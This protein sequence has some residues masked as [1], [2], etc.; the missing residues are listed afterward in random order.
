VIGR[1]A[2]AI[3]FV[4]ALC[5]VAWAVGP[6]T[7]GVVF[8]KVFGNDDGETR[9]VDV[10]LKGKLDAVE[11]ATVGGWFL[12]RRRG[13]QTFVGRGEIETAPEGER[14]FRPAKGWVNFTLGCDSRGFL[15]GTIN[16]NGEM[17]FPYVTLDDVPEQSWSQL[18]VVKQ[19]DGVHR[20]YRNGVKVH[21]NAEMA[22]TGKVW[23]FEDTAD[24]EPLR[25]G[26]PLGGKVGEAWVLRRALSDD[27]VKRDFDEKRERYKPASVPK[28]IDLRP[29]HERPIEARWRR[30]IT[31]ENW[32][33]ERERILRG[34]REVVGRSDAARVDLEIRIESPDVDCG[35]Y[36]R[37][38][39][40]IPVEA[41]DRM[42]VYLLVPKKLEG[43]VPAV[44]CMYG[45]TGGAGKETTVGLSG[46]TPGTPVKKNRSFAVD[47]AEAGMVA[48]APD[49][50]RDGERV[51]PG[52]RPYQT[53]G[54]Y[55]RHP[56]WSTVG[57][58]VW[59]ASRAIDY[60][61]TVPFVDAGRIGMMGHSYGGHTT[62]F[63]AALEERI[64]AAVASGPVSD[65]R[66]HGMHWGVPKGAGNSQSLPGMRPYVLDHSLP[67]PV[68]FYE[69]TALIAPRPLLVLQAVGER[70][71][72]E[73]E[74]AAAVGEVYRALGAHD[75]VRYLWTPGDHDFPPAARRAAVEWLKAGLGVRQ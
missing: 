44:I 27:E 68:E 9:R 61:E 72:H 29:M 58:D 34:V 24:D 52:E 32:P 42:P 17:P 59:D 16:G 55:E 66:G 8:H 30:P 50:L 12:P 38:K 23:P 26:V 7:E 31:K 39:V 67:I 35:T 2:G 18:V 22:A 5:G 45:T 62:I 46:P 15:T 40:S 14:M 3:V 36:V 11:S 41:G 19:K 28:Q 74:N 54:F 33:A 69:W 53:K 60:L 75:R 65:F 57:K 64:K 70:R 25:V 43:R 47:V 48:V 4:V 20:F 37:R 6:E 21:D 56:D 49:Y 13:E 1:V 10:P 73:E 63:A 51:R 71:P